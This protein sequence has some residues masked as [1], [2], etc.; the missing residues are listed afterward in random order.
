VVSDR[1]QVEVLAQFRLKL[2]YP[3]GRRKPRLVIED[4]ITILA[5]IVAL[6]AMDMKGHAEKPARFP[7]LMKYC[8]VIQIRCGHREAP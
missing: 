3:G 5:E 7:S 4:M 8:G 6:W 1:N 2:G